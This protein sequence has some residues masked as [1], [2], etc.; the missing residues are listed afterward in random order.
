MF[1]FYFRPQ[2]KVLSDISTRDTLAK[3][4]VSFQEMEA[5]LKTKMQN[6]NTELNEI[7]AVVKDKDSRIRSLEQELAIV[8]G[9]IVEGE[10]E[11]KRMV[12]DSDKFQN[13]IADL[14]VELQVASEYV[15]KVEEMEREIL[16]LKEIVKQS[17][18]NLQESQELK[19][20]LQEKKKRDLEN[21]R[22]TND[23]IASMQVR[24]I[25]A[26]SHFSVYFYHCL[27]LSSSICI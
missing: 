14:E 18:N 8:N 15:T 16:N 23:Q 21:L 26:L 25:F 24:V 1:R 10:E 7:Q 12:V 11:R 27:Y 2:N 6:T 17:E 3:T 20:Q 5:K 22:K 19:T 13:K 4:K 9:T